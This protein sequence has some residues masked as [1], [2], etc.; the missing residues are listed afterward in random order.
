MIKQQ[1]AHSARHPQQKPA[2]DCFDIMPTSGTDEE[3]PTQATP[4]HLERATGSNSRTDKT[5][6]SVETLAPASESTA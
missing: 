1:D 4:I 3:M 2:P 6:G 5:G